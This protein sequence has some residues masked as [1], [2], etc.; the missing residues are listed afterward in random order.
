VKILGEFKKLGIRITDFMDKLINLEK[1]GAL[2]RSFTIHDFT[3]SIKSFNKDTPKKKILE[4]F[5]SLDTESNGTIDSSEMLKLWLRGKEISD[6][7][8]ILYRLLYR[9]LR[10]TQFP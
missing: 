7:E 10:E 3:E 1:K 6:S 8:D 2:V 4:L 5:R 9:H